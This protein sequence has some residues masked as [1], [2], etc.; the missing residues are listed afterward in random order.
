[1]QTKSTTF[2]IPPQNCR[3]SYLAKYNNFSTLSNLIERKLLRARLRTLMLEREISRAIFSTKSARTVF[4]RANC[5][6]TLPKLPNFLIPSDSETAV[7]GQWKITVVKITENN[8]TRK[9]SKNVYLTTKKA[10]ISYFFIMFLS[11][12]SFVFLIS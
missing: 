11:L 1:M 3:L 10:T 12:S 8:L 4:T 2:Y 5:R 9:K 7:T 6:S